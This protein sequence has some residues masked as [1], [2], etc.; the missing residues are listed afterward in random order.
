MFTEINAGVDK[1]VEKVV[2]SWAVSIAQGLIDEKLNPMIDTIIGS[3]IGNV[4]NKGT[5]RENVKNDL[6][7]TINLPK[8]TDTSGMTDMAVNADGLNVW[9]TMT[10]GWVTIQCPSLEEDADLLIFDMSG[11]IIHR[12]KLDAGE[13]RQ[14]H[15]HFDTSGI[16][17]IKLTGHH[18]AVKV[19]D[20]K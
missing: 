14:I 13:G 8:Q 5:D 12:R 3:L 11:R 18:N 17:A 4:T 1:L 2:A 6:F 15:Y 10:D 19:I 16:H 7:L 9:P 20:N